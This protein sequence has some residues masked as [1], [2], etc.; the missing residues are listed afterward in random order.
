M[1]GLD[2]VGETAGS[3]VVRLGCEGTCIEVA[4][5]CVV[6]DSELGGEWA[7]LGDL[8]LDRECEEKMESC[9]SARERARLWKGNGKE[10]DRECEMG[11]E[12]G[13]LATDVVVDVDIVL[14]SVV[15]GMP[16]VVLTG[17]MEVALGEDKG[18]A[19]PALIFL[20]CWSSVTESSI[21]GL[22]SRTWGSQRR[23]EE[24]GRRC[25]YRR[26]EESSSYHLGGLWIPRVLEGAVCVRHGPV[27]G[28]ATHG[29][30]G[31]W[32]LVG[33]GRSEEGQLSRVIGLSKPWPQ[34]GAGL[35]QPGQIAAHGPAA[36]SVKLR[37]QRSFGRAALLA[38]RP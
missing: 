17:W 4:V 16:V 25:R 6:F 18:E 12:V 14:G 10:R 23:K 30:A 26:W 19:F 2:T 5:I 24:G 21:E 20:V 7:A 3:E 22:H 13:E 27:R 33:N 37:R 38:S 34:P 36:W 29:G 15:G 32:E 31:V 28:S 35:L 11:S 1:V 8:D 9:V